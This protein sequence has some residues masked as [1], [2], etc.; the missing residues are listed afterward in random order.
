MTR[1]DMEREDTEEK[2]A[3]L[4]RELAEND[5]LIAIERGACEEFQAKA[6]EYKRLAYEELRKAEPYKRRIDE[7]QK[8]N[9]AI[10]RKLAKLGLYG[11]ES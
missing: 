7:L 5:G 2:I 8:R 1:R 3:A 9:M 10:A 4:K 11:G 6:E